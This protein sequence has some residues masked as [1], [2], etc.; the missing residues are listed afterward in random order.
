V[1][2]PESCLLFFRLGPLFL[3]GCGV[4]GGGS[5]GTCFGRVVLKSAFRDLVTT[6]ATEEAKVVIHPTLAFLLGQLA[7]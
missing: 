1:W 7:T 3:L 6:F 4:S 2:S 5:G